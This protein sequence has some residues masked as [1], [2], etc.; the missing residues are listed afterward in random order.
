M[1]NKSQ[2]RI[3]SLVVVA[4]AGV[5]AL[6]GLSRVGVRTAAAMPDATDS[7][8]QDCPTVGGQMLI[9][10]YD[11]NVTKAQHG[12]PGFDSDGIGDKSIPASCNTN[13]TTAG[14]NYAA[15]RLYFRARIDSKN[16]DTKPTNLQFCIW[17]KVGSGARR[18]TCSKLRSAAVGGGFVTWDEP[19]NG[20]WK[21]NGV[22]LDWSKPR[23]WM[24][25]AIKSGKFPVSDWTLPRWGNENPDRWYPMNAC[26]QVVAVPQG[27]GAPN[28]SNFPCN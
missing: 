5:L 23:L 24:R 7:L 12:F 25:Y 16:G 1:E 14:A 8:R 21:K 2:I 13:W 28:W 11:G 18:E 9:F 22:A 3:M 20:M 27:G 26:L 4:L 19:T 10:N 17:Q 15:G 6:V